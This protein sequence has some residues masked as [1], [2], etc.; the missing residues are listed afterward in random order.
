MNFTRYREDLQ[1]HFAR[2][3]LFVL[4][5]S[6]FRKFYVNSSNYN[7][8]IRIQEDNKFNIFLCGILT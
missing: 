6:L 1:N 7:N 8:I 4:F 2:F 5:N 3:I